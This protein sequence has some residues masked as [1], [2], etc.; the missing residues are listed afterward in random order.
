M[1]VLNEYCHTHVMES[2]LK[3]DLSGKFDHLLELTRYFIY[4][5]IEGRLIEVEMIL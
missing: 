3:H 5:A 1:K 2:K 4:R